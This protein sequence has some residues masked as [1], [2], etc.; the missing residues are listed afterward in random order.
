LIRLCSSKALRTVTPL[1]DG[2]ELRRLLIRLSFLD[3]VRLC[4]SPMRVAVTPFDSNDA[5]HVY[6]PSFLELESALFEP[7]HC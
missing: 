5:A 4:S 3:F 6:S 7:A 1:D 2:E